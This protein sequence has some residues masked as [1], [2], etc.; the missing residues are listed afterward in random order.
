[1]NDIEEKLRHLIRVAAHEEGSVEAWCWEN[2]LPKSTISDFMRSKS[3]LRFST[4]SKICVALGVELILNV[5][6][7]YDSTK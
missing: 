6:N 4:L 7:H 5:R 3:D 2:E 1:M